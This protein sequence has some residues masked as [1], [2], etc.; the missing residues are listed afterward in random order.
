MKKKIGILN[1]S[2]VVQGDSNE[3]T[4][5]EI[6]IIRNKSTNL[7]ED[8][9]EGGGSKNSLLAKSNEGEGCFYLKFKNSDYGSNWTPFEDMTLAGVSFVKTNFFLTWFSGQSLIISSDTSVSLLFLLDSSFDKL[10]RNEIWYVKIYNTTISTQEGKY[11][12]TDLK[13]FKE[14]L[15]Y[16]Y[17]SIT[18]DSDTLKHTCSM[19]DD[20]YEEATK[21]EY[22]QQVL[23]LFSLEST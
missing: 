5:N 17:G 2:P 12:V 18:S 3:I 14:Y 6:Q 15:Y 13:S 7:I 23:D 9:K 21:E 20:T 10:A 8:I 19:I 16:I 1:G 11:S 22:E 4:K